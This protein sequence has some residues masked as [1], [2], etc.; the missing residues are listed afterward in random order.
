MEEYSLPLLEEEVLEELEA[1]LLDLL[2][3]PEVAAEEGAEDGDEV[4]VVV[5]EALREAAALA[6]ERLEAEEQRVVRA[7]EPAVEHD[8]VHVAVHHE[9][10]AAAAG[11]ARRPSTTAAASASHPARCRCTTL[12]V[13]NGTVMIRRIFRQWSPY[14]V[15]T[16]SCPLPVK[17]SNTTLRVRDPNSTPCVWSTSRAS[18]GEETTT[19][20]R[21]PIRRRK[22]SPNLRASAARLRWLRSS[23]T[24]SQLPKTGTG[25]GP[26]GRR[27]FRPRSLDTAIATTA[28]ARR[29]TR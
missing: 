29:P 12:P 10:Q 11:S 5:L 2:A 21:C 8:A 17:M 3:D 16:M 27:S 25:V 26:G 23:P 20:L 28:A 4:A 14:T 15:N 13:K 7:L 6:V 9:L 24:C 22:M 1:G 18:G 19:R